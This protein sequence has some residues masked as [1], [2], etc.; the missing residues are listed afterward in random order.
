MTTCCISTAAP[1][2]TPKAASSTR[3]KPA[4]RSA[5]ARWTTT[6]TALAP[7][8][9][10]PPARSRA[11]APIATA[12]PIARSMKARPASAAGSTRPR[13]RASR[14]RNPDSLF[15]ERA[16]QRAGVLA[17]ARLDQELDLG[18]AHR[19]GAEDALVLDFDD[20]AAGVGD[21]LR[22][23]REAARDIRH[24]DAQAHEARIAHQAAHQHRGEHAAVDVAP[25]DRD[26]D[27]L[28]GE[29]L[30]MLE[31]RRERRGAGALGHGLFDL[32]QRDD[33]AL[34][35][36]FLDHQD[37]FHQLLDHGERHVADVLH[38]DAFGDGVAA[39][40]DRL[41]LEPLVHRG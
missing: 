40:L 19:G 3:S 28:A 33:A 7:A 16:H 36:L 29:A 22:H 13:K 4:L 8:S 10:S 20:V 18:R 21:E 30:R 25:R 39:H 9:T 15:L 31:Q 32:D 11:S 2:K 17:V 37:F 41:A 26:A 14:N 12:I 5:I 27:A 24:R 23:L 6:A 34:D 1:T 38:R 35:G